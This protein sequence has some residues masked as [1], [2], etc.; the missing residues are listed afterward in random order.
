MAQWII[1]YVVGAYGGAPGLGA[2]INVQIPGPLRRIV[3]GFYLDRPGGVTGPPVPL[4]PVATANAND[5]VMIAS[6]TTYAGKRQIRIYTGA[7]LANPTI[8][9]FVETEKGIAQP[10]GQPQA[11]PA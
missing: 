9:L 3:S 10:A 6:Q 2:T 4:T 1:A 11:I 8:Y 5:E 7:A